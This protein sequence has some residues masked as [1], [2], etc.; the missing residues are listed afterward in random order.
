[1]RSH[2]IE[3]RGCG[4]L[5]TPICELPS[6]T[7]MCQTEPAARWNPNDARWRRHARPTK[8]RIGSGGGRIRVPAPLDHRHALDEWRV[9]RGRPITKQLLVTADAFDPLRPHKHG[10]APTRKVERPQ[11]EL[12]G[13]RE[14]RIGDDPIGLRQRCVMQEIMRRGAVTVA[15]DIGRR[16]LRACKLS[17]HRR[18]VTLATRRLPHLVDRIDAQRRQH[19]T[20]ESPR[21]PRRR[22]EI[23][24]CGGRFPPLRHHRGKAFCYQS[25]VT[26]SLV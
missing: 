22:R 5:E 2:A 13:K 6:I 1:V 9:Q 10:H 11:R 26:A 25:H 23:I 15:V 7:R 16:D 4:R 3:Q 21:G 8:P 20:E 24:E 19:M 17:N 18:H 14:R 12:A